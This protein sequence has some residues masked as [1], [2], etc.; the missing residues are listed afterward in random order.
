MK[1]PHYSKLKKDKTNIT[2]TNQINIG[3]VK[4]LSYKKL[5]VGET[6]SINWLKYVQ[7]D[8]KFCKVQVRLLNINALLP[9]K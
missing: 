5:T 2:R 7:V 4:I 6:L 1:N 3:L 9:N 8:D